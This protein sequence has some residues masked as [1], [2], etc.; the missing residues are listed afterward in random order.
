MSRCPIF[1]V[2]PRT[3]LPP[4]ECCRGKPEPCGKVGPALEYVHWRRE[5]LD[6]HGSDGPVPGIV[7][8]RLV[9]PPRS[10]S[11]ARVAFSSS[12]TFFDNPSIWSK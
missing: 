9:V 3:C 5:G 2:F 12:A 10:A 6:R 11:K 1:E 8:R 7:L 4:V